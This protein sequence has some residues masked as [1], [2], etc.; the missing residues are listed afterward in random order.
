MA[1]L[2]VQ[3]MGLQLENPL[4]V[5][6][7]GLTRTAEQVKQCEAAGAGAV[8]L[9]SLFEEEIQAHIDDES[10]G[11]EHTEALDYIRELETDAG[12]QGYTKVIHEAKASVNI[13][14]I[15]SINAV[16][17][18]WWEDHVAEI[19]QAGADALELNIS[20]MPYDYKSN[21]ADILDFYI[22]T[23]EAVRARV[24][25][26]IAVKIGQHF[27]SI[28]ALVDRLRWAGA[29]A[30][31]LFNRFYQLDIDIETLRLQ[32]GSP[33][34]I[35]ADLALTLRWL[36]VTYGK[37]EAQLA[38]NGGIHT[39]AD[40]VKALLAGAEV[41]QVC[42]TL[43]QNQYSHL[44]TMRDEIA[45]WMDRH[46]YSTI[47]Q[48]RGKLSQKKSSTPEAFERLQYIKALVGHE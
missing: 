34:S 37:T 3:Y 42:S 21:E 33:L 38:A 5:S 15:A 25:I 48:F 1:D 45:S 20:L 30:V 43:Y 31:V 27:T 8:V 2:R 46:G 35:P 39:G 14:V 22:R 40:A 28:P 12:I 11:A 29:Q 23:V 4:V 17:R 36:T 9:K 7:S 41:T 18:N 24:N 19:A 13:P 32:S 10:G 44:T 47:G 16:T 6:S 26:P